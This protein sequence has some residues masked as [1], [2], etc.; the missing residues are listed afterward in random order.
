M[1]FHCYFGYWKD[2]VWMGEKQD[3]IS[4]CALYERCDNLIKTESKNMQHG[5]VGHKVFFERIFFKGWNWSISRGDF[6]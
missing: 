6:I 4:T 3:A 1:L 5:K 2:A